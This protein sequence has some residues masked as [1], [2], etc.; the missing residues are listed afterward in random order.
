[1]V[2]GLKAYTKKSEYVDLYCYFDAADTTSPINH[3]AMK[4]FTAY[5][6]D[7]GGLPP[8]GIR[9]DV[10]H[11]LGASEG[12]HRDVGQRGRRRRW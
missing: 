12:Y 9:G 8:H 1:M 7:I 2:R 6:K 11:S 5:P 10:L 3:F 4:A